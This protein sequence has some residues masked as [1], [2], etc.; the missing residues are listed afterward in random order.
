LVKKNKAG[1]KKIN[2]Q[3]KTT[4]NHSLQRE[5]SIILKALILILCHFI[6]QR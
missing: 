6:L 3:T 1:I 4:K 2:T 5:L